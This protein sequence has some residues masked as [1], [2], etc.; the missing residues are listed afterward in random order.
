V[1]VLEV[2]RWCG[3]HGF[4]KYRNGTSAFAIDHAETLLR[5][6]NKNRVT[7]LLPPNPQ[8]EP[9]RR[10]I[11]RYP[12]PWARDSFATLARRRTVLL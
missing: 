11:G 12:I 6:P 4:T 7:C 5:V 9:S 10:T 2:R 8:M 3:Q 1:T